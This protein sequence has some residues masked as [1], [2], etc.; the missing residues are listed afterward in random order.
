LG[1]GVSGGQLYV[2]AERGVER[3]HD[4]RS[5]RHVWGNVCEPGLSAD[6]LDLAVGG[7]RIELSPVV[8]SQDRAD[9]PF[10]DGQVKGRR[11]AAVTGCGSTAKPPS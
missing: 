2:A 8:A 1:F 9:G 11:A 6:R 7:A 5:A 10:P 3:R 4:E